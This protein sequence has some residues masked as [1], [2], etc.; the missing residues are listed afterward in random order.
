MADTTQ[1]QSVLPAP[2]HQNGLALVTVI[3]IV[4]VVSS[5]AVFMS[6]NQQVWYRQSSNILERA[7]G[8][9]SYRSALAM[10]TI[11]LERDATE[12]NRD[13]LQEVWA[14]QVV[15]LPIESGHVSVAI[16][17]AQ[18]RFNLNNLLKNG[19][20]DAENIGVFRRLLG[21]QGVSE[22]LVEPLV[23][24]MDSDTQARPGGAEDIEYLASKTPYRA[25]NHPLSDIG[26]LRLIKGFTPEIVSKLSGFVTALPTASAININTAPPAVLAALFTDM[27]LPAAEALA[28]TLAERPLT[29]ATDIQNLAGTDHKLGKAA[30]DTKSSYFLISTETRNGR[31]RNQ[32]ITLVY[33]PESGLPCRTLGKTRPTIHMTGPETSG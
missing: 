8:E 7:R 19:Q 24:W 23:D 3:L 26:E 14:K 16:E 5:I 18:G 29:R 21:N 27:P 15:A 28:K 2:H 32:V 4:S 33:R 20:P 13:D 17:D 9:N 1:N 30:I 22:S 12:T 10:A 25:A 11:V 6:L 31:Y